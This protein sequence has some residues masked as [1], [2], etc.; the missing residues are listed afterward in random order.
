MRILRAFADN[1]FAH[2]ILHLLSGIAMYLLIFKMF[3]RLELAA[4]AFLVSLLVDV[5]HYLEGFIVNHFDIRWIF[6]THPYIYWEKLGKVTILFHSWELLIVIF[7]F[8]EIV[9]Q[10]TLSIVIICPL[11]LHYVVDTFIYCGFRNMPILQ[12]F[13]AYRICRHFDLKRFSPAS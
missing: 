5:D 3:G 12:Y 10:Q 9:N 6:S 1:L 8:G 2:E 4:V 11:F 7:I 13:L